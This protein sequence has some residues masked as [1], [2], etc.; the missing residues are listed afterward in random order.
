M[1]TPTPTAPTPGRALGIDVARGLALMAMFVAHTAPWEG[2]WGR[3][4]LADSVTAPM[5]AALV[6]AGLYLSARRDTSGVPLVSAGI[7]AT[8]LLVVGTFLLWMPSQ[9]DVVLLHLAMLTIVAALVVRLPGYWPGL[10]LLLVALSGPVL[11]WG[12]GQVHGILRA[13]EGTRDFLLN[14]AVGGTH[15]RL[16]TFMVWAVVGMAFARYLLGAA[17]RTHAVLAAVAVVVAVLGVVLHRTTP[18]QLQ[19]Y[20]GWP[21]EMV[22]ASVLVVG[23]LSTG[24]LLAA[25]AP[26]VASALATAGRATLSV[27]A[28]QV[29]FLAMWVTTWGHASDDSWWTLGLLVVGSVV[30]PA[31]WVSALPGRGPVELVV[32]TLARKVTGTLTDRPAPSL[33]SRSRT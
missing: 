15:Y 21:T 10:V 28:A 24:F 14:I 12:R 27:Y 31:L 2:V 13:E 30:L 32:D 6:G 3:R 22:Y 29:V 26:P 16:L 19:P 17:L 5:F 20:T 9:V 1:S 11:A 33:P 23:I 4:N 7:R 18:V 25:Y 8:A